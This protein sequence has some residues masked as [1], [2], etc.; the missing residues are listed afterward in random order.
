MAGNREECRGG[1]KY[2]NADKCRRVDEN[3]QSKLGKKCKEM[4]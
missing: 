4:N 3:M 1:K 2:M